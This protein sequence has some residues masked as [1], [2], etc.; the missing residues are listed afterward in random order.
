MIRFDSRETLVNLDGVMEVIHRAIAVAKIPPN[1]PLSKGG[2]T[3]GICTFLL[4]ICSLLMAHGSL[5]Y[6]DTSTGS[7]FLNIGA[8]AKSLALGEAYTARSGDSESLFYNPAAL[9]ELP[10]AELS[11]TY[12][13]WLAGTAFGIVSYA[14]PTRIGTLA[15]G[16]LNLGG[17]TQDGRDVNRQ[18]TGTFSANDTEG[19]LS[20]SSAIGQWAAIGA[21]AKYLESRIGSDAASTVAFD[22]GGFA[23]APGPRPLTVGFSVLNIGSGLRFI[24]QVDRLPLT[25]AL[26]TAYKPVSALQLSADIK[27]QPYDQATELDMGAE[28]GLSLFDFRLGYQ[29][30]LENSN[31]ASL[32]AAERIRGGLGFHISRFQ[33][34]Y[35]L[36]PFGDLGLTQRITVRILF[37]LPDNGPHNLQH[38]GQAPSAQITELFPGL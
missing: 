32:S 16:V 10:Q 14:Q 4:L 27:H 5:L 31:D 34:D 11:A 23:A 22:A 25:L 24:D 19:L 37:G 26:G 8:G 30:P 29:A 36:A 17:G 28:Y 21:N 12:S 7:A 9:A 2:I 15:A 20:Y 35:T 33:A 38:A 6:A 13:D 1:P 18:P 3:A